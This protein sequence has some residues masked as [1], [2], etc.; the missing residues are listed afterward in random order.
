MVQADTRAAMESVAVGFRQAYD[1]LSTSLGEPQDI[2]ASGGGLL[3]SA[4]WTQMMADALGRPVTASTELEA[5][6]RGAVLWTLEQLRLTDSL[7]ALAASNGA[8]FEPRAEQQAA[9]EELM[10]RRQALYRKLYGTV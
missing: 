8:T 3:R 5:S 1:L 2:V 4:G 6:A 10:A 7:A 9:F